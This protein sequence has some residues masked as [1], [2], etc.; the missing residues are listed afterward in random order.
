MSFLGGEYSAGVDVGQ[1][2]APYVG[3]VTVFDL[4]RYSRCF[5]IPLY[6][7]PNFPDAAQK[8]IDKSLR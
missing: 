5:H 6:G 3:S 1:T 4:H 8:V 7:Q 2:L